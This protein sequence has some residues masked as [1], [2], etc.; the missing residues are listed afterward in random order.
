MILQK[1]KVRF[2]VIEAVLG[3]TVPGVAGVYQRYDWMP[4]MRESQE[5]LGNYLAALA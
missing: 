1:C 3:H 5:A 4:E 2:E